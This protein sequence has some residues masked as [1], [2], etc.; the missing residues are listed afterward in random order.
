MEGSLGGVV[1]RPSQPSREARRMPAIT[2]PN[3]VGRGRAKTIW[4]S[5]APSSNRLTPALM[6]L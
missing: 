6:L 2:L 5:I 4:A 3:Q 1:G